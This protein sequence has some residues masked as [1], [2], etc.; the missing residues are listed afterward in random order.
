ADQT[1]ASARLKDGGSRITRSKSWPVRRKRSSALKVSEATKSWSEGSR[2]FA[3]KLASARS[4]TLRDRSTVVTW[5]APLYAADTEKAPVYAKVFSTVAPPQ[6]GSS[7][8]RTSRMSQ[9]RPTS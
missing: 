7:Q 4:S 3:R 2:S 8:A 6:V 1:P 5:A 9:Y